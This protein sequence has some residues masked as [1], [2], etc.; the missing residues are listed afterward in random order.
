[1]I[2]EPFEARNCANASGELAPGSKQDIPMIAMSLRSS[3]GDFEVG[4]LAIEI[5][6]IFTFRALIQIQ[7]EMFRIGV[8]ASAILRPT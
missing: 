8:R 3:F 5:S 6:L 7:N 2:P 4:A 1:M